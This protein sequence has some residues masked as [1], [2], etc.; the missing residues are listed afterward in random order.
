MRLHLLHAFLVKVVLHLENFAIVGKSFNEVG[1]E[2]GE[3][4]QYAV[5]DAI[6]LDGFVRIGAIDGK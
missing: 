1:V 4:G 3:Y 6:T 2:F 5:A